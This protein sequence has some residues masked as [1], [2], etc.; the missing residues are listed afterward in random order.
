M[1]ILAIGAHFDDIELGCGGSLL[2]HVGNGDTVTGVV[3][4]HS[5]YRSPTGDVV[6]DAETASR[7]GVAAA[8]AIGYELIQLGHDTL[9]VRFDEELTAALSSI[10]GEREIDLV[11]GHWGGD[12]HRDH[13]NVARCTLMACRHVPRHL[14]YRSNFYVTDKSFCGTFFSDISPFI[15]NKMETVGLFRSELD[16]V[17]NKW[18]ELFRSHHRM[19]GLVIGVENA[20]VF[21]VVRYLV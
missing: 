1:N 16:R 2:K 7:E 12:L 8:Q 4:T 17:N 15:E 9:D 3:V 11:Y 20:E 6:R 21:E 14:A 18:I 5:G 13:S 19:N 10:V